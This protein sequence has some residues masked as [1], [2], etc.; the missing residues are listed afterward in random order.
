MAKS[1]FTQAKFNFIGHINY[2]QTPKVIQN[3]RKDG[4]GNLYKTKLGIGIKH[5]SSCPFLQMEVLHD[6]KEPEKI[7]VIG[8]DGKTL[9]EVPYNMTNTPE[10]MSRVADFTK[11][12]IDLE[13][14]F[15]KKKEYMGLIY[16][17]RNHEFKVSELEKKKEYEGLTTEEEAELEEHKAKIEIYKQEVSEKATNRH[18]FIMKDAIDFINENLP[19]M[20]K[21][22][23]RVLGDARSNYYNDVNKFQYI[24]KIIEY[25]PND[26]ENQLKIEATV[27]FDKNSIIDKDKEKKILING[28]VPE[29]KKKVTTLYPTLFVLDYNKLDLTL[30][31]HQ[32]ILD[33]MKGTF[34]VKDKKSVYRVPLDIELIDGA[35]E[36]EF[37]EADLTKEQKQ[38][39][40]LGFNT[41]DDF[42][43]KNKQFG[44]NKVEYRMIK[45]ILKDD[46]ASGAVV[47]F[48]LKD[49]VSYLP[50]DESDASEDD[51]PN[52]NEQDVEDSSSNSNGVDLDALFGSK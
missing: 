44:E 25:V 47:S 5:N 28:Y 38:L 48:A 17:I 32:S 12:T 18:E 4:K 20:K 8:L 36:K 15:E 13:T 23:V 41:I 31:S 39:I 24:P 45:P 7:K 11:I 19:E 34:K 42:K 40:E 22:K 49:L 27:F 1:I 16:K 37:T 29:T 9:V 46:F 51:T 10:V 30:E 3:A 33:F 14:D 26:T 52:N 21:H 35:E 6:G 2:G 43:P 50:K